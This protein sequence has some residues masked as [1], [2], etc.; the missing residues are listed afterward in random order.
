MSIASFVMG[1]VGPVVVRGIT[2]LGFTAVTFSGVT[3]LANQMVSNAQSSWSQMPATVLQL[4]SLSGIPEALG[5][6]MG[7]YIAVLA[8]KASVGFSKYILKR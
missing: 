1:L 8:L 6:I 4:A 3:E 2:A 5:M 7:A